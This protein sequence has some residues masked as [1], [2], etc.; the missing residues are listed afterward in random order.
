MESKHNFSFMW[1][2]RYDHAHC[3]LRSEPIELLQSCLLKMRQ[4]D[5]RSEL[6]INIMQVCYFLLFL[7]L[8]AVNYKS[9]AS[10]QMSLAAGYITILIFKCLL[11]KHRPTWRANTVLYSKRYTS[12]DAARVRPAK[13]VLCIGNSTLRPERYD[14]HSHV[15]RSITDDY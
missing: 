12:A 11:L 13:S 7:W 1:R 6:I 8:L 2:D 15:Q 4:F 9:V 5:S 14:D 3:V 10:L